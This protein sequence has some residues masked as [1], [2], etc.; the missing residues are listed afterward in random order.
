MKRIISMMMVLVIFCGLSLVAVPEVQASNALYWTE[1]EAAEKIREHILNGDERFTIMVATEDFSGEDAFNRVMEI[2]WK[3]TGDPKQGD[4]LKWRLYG[5]GATYQT[6]NRLTYRIH[7]FSFIAGYN[8]TTAQETELDVAIEELLT[9]LD[10]DKKSDYEKVCAV[11]EYI[12]S[13]VTYDYENLNDDNYLL[14]FSAYAALM[15]KTAVCQGYAMLLYR[16]LLELGVENRIVAGVSNG[17][18]HAWNIVK[19]DGHYYNLDATW[20]AGNDEYLYF[21]KCRE[22]FGDHARYLNYASMDFCREHPMSTTDYV[23]HASVETDQYVNGGYCSDSVSWDLTLDGALTFSGTGSIKDYPYDSTDQRVLAPWEYYEE[24]VKKLNVGEGITRIGT[25]NFCDMVNLTSVSLPSTLREIGKSAF[26]Y[27]K[28]LES[29]VIPDGVTMLE[30]CAFRDCDR[31]ITITIP[32]SVQQIG[33]AVFTDCDNLTSIII[34][35]SP[36]M[37]SVFFQN[38]NALKAIYFCSDAPSFDQ[39]TFDGEVVTCYYPDGNPTWTDEV[40]QDYGGTVTW[41]ADQCSGKHTEVTDPA[42]AATCTATGLTEG[43]HCSVCGAVLTAQEVTPAKGHSYGPWVTIKEPTTDAEGLS[44]RTCAGCGDVE[45]KPI[46]KLEPDTTEP[47]VTE[48]EETEPIETEPAVTEP[49]ETDPTEPS[50]KEPEETD[51][52]APETTDP[53]ANEKEE[54][55]DDSASWVLPVVCCV[56]VAVAAGI[57]VVVIRKKKKA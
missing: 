27:N 6:T 49:A 16:L 36:A 34:E 24:E 5:L 22:N 26:S 28:S 41:I 42:V 48:P 14:K 39:R 8:T 29:I 32:A 15:D 38:C 4:Y 19:L 57:A 25:Y 53:P 21:L 17:E 43:S 51:P 52:T 37:D 55:D 56:I 10:L 31:L 12:C 45:E 7:T 1:E 11:Y 47:D 54:P 23:E 13:N 18:S 2:V 30:D 50:V 40:L 46:A 9:Q 20:D 33:T 44:H 3:H 35:G